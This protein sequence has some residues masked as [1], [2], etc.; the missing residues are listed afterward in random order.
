MAVYLLSP[1]QVRAEDFTRLYRVYSGGFC[2]CAARLQFV[3]THGETWAAV[4]LSGLGQGRV[5]PGSLRGKK[6]NFA[7][8]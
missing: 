4:F 2:Q 1:G 3:L 8:E 6:I 5:A 7:I